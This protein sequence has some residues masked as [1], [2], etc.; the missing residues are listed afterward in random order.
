LRRLC[1]EAL[2]QP[3]SGDA[4]VQVLGLLESAGMAFDALW[5][6]GL[7]DDAWPLRAR[8]NPFLPIGLQRMAGI[9]ES[10]AE[11]SLELDRR[12][13]GGWKQ[14]AEEVIF[15]SPRRTED[16]DLSPSPLIAA[17]AETTVEVP[18][19]PG[20]RDL[21]FASRA[22]HVEED[23][24]AP[25]V[26]ARTVRGGTR[27]LADQAACP[28]RAYARWRLGA[29]TLE[30]PA[31]GPDA[32]DR[33]MLLHALMAGIWKEART[34]AGLNAS[35][36]SRSAKAA[37]AGLGLE[38]RF[39]ELEVQRLVK[40]A[41]EWLDAERERKPFEVVHVEAKRSLTIGTLEFTGRIDRMDRLEDGSH[42]VIDYK[43]GSRVTPNDWLG[44]RPD[45][46]QLPLYAV[47]AE[48][49][50]SALAF[51]KLRTGDMKFLGF[52]SREKEIPGVKAAKSWDGLVADWRTELTALAGGFASG[53][54]P[55]D[56]KRGLKTCQNCD[57]HPLC[58]VHER[59][60]GEA[61]DD[62]GEPG[63]M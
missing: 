5:V 18:A 63:E 55:V 53:E 59:I 40:L 15:S 19:F 2:F 21:I 41:N 29:E 6:S 25:P 61:E 46:P 38:G 22:V 10:S 57:L 42:A 20:W 45:D 23:S 27:V 33:G 8:P 62:A 4:P 54:A 58:R 17:I 39:A 13:T 7:T 14:A 9:P 36:I 60:G 43:T 37:V 52:S 26:A 1:N 47:T 48:E 44:P 35:L 3:E 30:S 32:L 16:R 31:Q 51:A 24:R 34:P 49:K 50:V 56:P 12:I 11:G 28:F